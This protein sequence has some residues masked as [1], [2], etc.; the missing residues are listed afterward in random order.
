M[1]NTYSRP[2]TYYPRWITP[3]LAQ[4]SHDHPVVVLTGARQVGKSTLL[5]NEEPFRNWRFRN[6]DDIDTLRAA[7]ESPED[8]WAG[9][10]KIGAIGVRISRWITSHGFAFNV[11]TDLQY[12]DLIVPCGI[13]ERGVTSLRQQLGREVPMADVEESLVHHFAQV[14]SRRVS[15]AMATPA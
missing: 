12:F 2:E 6:L 1:N 3:L 5:L 11:N 8:L 13:A 10:D 4:A 9:A 14:F 15:R 7:H